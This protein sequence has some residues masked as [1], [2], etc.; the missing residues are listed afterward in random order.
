MHSS[1]SWLPTSLSGDPVQLGCVWPRTGGSSKFAGIAF[2]KV[3]SL[4]E[5]GRVSKVVATLQ[6]LSE[7]A[8]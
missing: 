4:S 8:I 7:K 1:K 5:L 6:G 2:N 3:Q